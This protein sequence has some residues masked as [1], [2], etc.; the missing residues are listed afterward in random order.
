MRKD[1][2]TIQ[3]ILKGRFPGMEYIDI[4]TDAKLKDE[5]RTLCGDDKALPPQ[6]FNGNEYCGV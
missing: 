2:Q 3:D 6:I 4:S 5:M 1:I